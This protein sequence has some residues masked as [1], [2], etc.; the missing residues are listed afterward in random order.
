MIR[1]NNSIKMEENSRMPNIG[2]ED[3]SHLKKVKECL[4]KLYEE[5]ELLFTR[6]KGRGL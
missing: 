4:N 1:P 3:I 2:T 6:N 5:D